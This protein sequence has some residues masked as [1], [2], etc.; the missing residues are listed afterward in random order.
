[1]TVRELIAWLATQ[2]QDAIVE[3]IRREP[4]GYGYGGDSFEVVEFV[5]EEHS[6][7]SDFRNNQHTSPDAPHYG[8]R[9]LLLGD[10]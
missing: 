7:Y 6:D 8:K 1:M 4:G 5:P 3:V 2:D 10:R 9:F